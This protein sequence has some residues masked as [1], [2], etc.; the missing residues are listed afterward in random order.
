M[1]HFVIVTQSK[2]GVMESWGPYPSDDDAR[3]DW[4]SICNT[5]TQEWMDNLKFMYVIPAQQPPMYA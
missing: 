3:K 1:E 4:R 5:Q 2:Y